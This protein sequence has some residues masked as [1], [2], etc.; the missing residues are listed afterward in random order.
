MS[1]VALAE[2]PRKYNL[3]VNPARMKGAEYERTLWVVTAE[4]GTTREDLLQP[5]YWAHV[6]GQLKAYDRLEVR[7]DD[8]TFYAEYLVLGVSHVSAKVWELN[9][10][11]LSK[12]DLPESGLYRVDWGGP[13]NKWVIIRVADGA[14]I[15]V[16]LT[17]DDAVMHAAE[18]EKRTR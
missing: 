4:A 12:S 10:Q 1:Q 17:K 8:D 11:A 2:A 3:Q 13:H 18:M 15:E 14:K 5:S 7:A 6:A 9:W 16:G